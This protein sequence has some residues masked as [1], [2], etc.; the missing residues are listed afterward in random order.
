VRVLLLDSDIVAYRF[1][2]A[3]ESATAWD[4]DTWT[5]IGNL[6]RAKMGVEAFL[7]DISGFT[8]CGQIYHYLSDTKANWRRDIMPQYK[9][10]RAG[11]KIERPGILPPKPGPKRPMLWKPL[12]EWIAEEFAALT[13]GG[14][15]G[16]DLLGMAATNPHMNLGETVIVSED[17]DMLTVPGHHFNPRRPH[18]GIVEVTPRQA[19]Y[20]HLYQT[21]MGDATDGYKG[22]PGVGPKGAEKILDDVDPEGPE[23]W[24]KVVD[25]YKRK[26]LDEDVALMTARVAHVMQYG[27]YDEETKEVKL[28]EP[29]R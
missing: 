18:D 19:A 28:W 12:R 20:R 16:D 1:A 3:N 8:E 4:E 9:G 7:A 22:I 14:L 10:E 5:Y 13:V 17:K 27:D 15:E 26:G 6:D 24:E 29:V 2:H 23:A 25:A 21:L 11:W